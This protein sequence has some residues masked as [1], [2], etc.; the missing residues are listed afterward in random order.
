MKTVVFLLTVLI[1]V[2]L[3]GCCL[4]YTISSD[5]ILKSGKK[6][7]KDWEFQFRPAE[8]NVVNANPGLTV[9][10]MIGGE[11]YETLPFQ[12]VCKRFDVNLLSNGSYIKIPVSVMAGNKVA[13]TRDWY[14]RPQNTET[15]TWIIQVRGD[16]LYLVGS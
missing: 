14:V 4:S 16:Y 15:S 2:S 6:I 3:A 10:V 7:V 9:I 12:K 13:V 5:D 8:L 11:A 1:L